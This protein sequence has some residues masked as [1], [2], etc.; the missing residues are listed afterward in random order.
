MSG[1]L[2]DG[3]MTRVLAVG[4][5]LAALM[6]GSSRPP[7]GRVIVT[8]LPDSGDPAEVRGTHVRV[9]AA[10]GRIAAGTPLRVRWDAADLPGGAAARTLTI[11]RLGTNG[12]IAIPSHADGPSSIIGAIEQAGEFDLR[13]HARTTCSGDVAHA[14]DFRVGV[15][16]YRA[17]GFDPGRTTVTKDVSGCALLEHYV[18]VK[19]G[20]SESLFLVGDD[21]RWHVTTYDPS[22]RSVMPGTVDKNGV[23]FYHSATDREAYRR[24]PNGTATFAGERSVDGGR[25]WSTWVTAVYTRVAREP[26]PAPGRKQRPDAPGTDDHRDRHSAVAEDLR[27][28][29]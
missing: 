11:A 18:D 10:T 17:E 14:L 9:D 20:R 25:T 8:N 19:G 4:C 15:W 22:G 23:A 16:D 1:T 2:C 26:D 3:P 29:Q 12:W 21:G 27:R 28:F 24:G 7:A 6:P 13:W 5:L